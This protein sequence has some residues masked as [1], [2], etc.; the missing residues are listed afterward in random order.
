[1]FLTDWGMNLSLKIAQKHV[2]GLKGG[3]RKGGKQMNERGGGRRGDR[4]EMWLRVW[5]W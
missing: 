4:G 5:G 2:R 1:M 3:D